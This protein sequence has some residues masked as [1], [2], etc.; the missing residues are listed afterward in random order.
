[1][2]CFVASKVAIG[3]TSTSQQEAAEQKKALLQGTLWWTW[4]KVHATTRQLKLIAWLG[5]N[6]KSFH[7]KK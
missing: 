3:L 1:M 6:T 5:C 4:A 7:P 2:N